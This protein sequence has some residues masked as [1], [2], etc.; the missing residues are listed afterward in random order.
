LTGDVFLSENFPKD[1]YAALPAPLD[2]VKLLDIE[3]ERLENYQAEYKR[4]QS[5]ITE[6]EARIKTARARSERAAAE[7]DRQEAIA[8]S[9]TQVIELVH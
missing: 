4:I 2:A 7:A 8:R 9:L 6:E 3:K 1:Q 5:L